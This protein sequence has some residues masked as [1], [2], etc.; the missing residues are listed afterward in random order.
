MIRNFENKTAVLTGGGSGFGLEC[1]RIAARL[2]MNVVLVDVQQD[3]LD[4][5]EAEIARLSDVRAQAA[6][7]AQDPSPV[8]ALDGAAGR[9]EALAARLEQA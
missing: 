1:A 9:L 6:Q 4:K 3:A 2:K 8:T 7:A 5:A